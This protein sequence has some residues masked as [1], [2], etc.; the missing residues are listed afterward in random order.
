MPSFAV[1]QCAIIECQF[2]ASCCIRGQ[3]AVHRLHS[4]T[5]NT[6]HVLCSTSPQVPCQ[7]SSSLRL[8][9]VDAVN[10]PTAVGHQPQAPHKADTWRT[11]L[12]CTLQPYVLP[13]LAIPWIGCLAQ[14]KCAVCEQRMV[15]GRAA[16]Q[17][18]QCCLCFLRRGVVRLR[19]T[20]APSWHE[21]PVQASIV[22]CNL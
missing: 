3:H 17:L 18:P 10:H 5:C 21:V 2:H 11:H 8:L 13:K 1:L 20:R 6:L 22:G 4:T 16:E 12:A 9:C 19:R 7:Q 14:L 15:M